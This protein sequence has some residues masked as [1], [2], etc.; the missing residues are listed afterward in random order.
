MSDRAELVE[1]LRKT[2]DALEADGATPKTAGE[3]IIDVEQTRALLDAAESTLLLQFDQTL[4]C[5]AEGF[6]TT[7]AW[8]TQRCQVASATASRRMKVARALPKLPIVAERFT[9]GALSFDQVECFARALNERTAD[10]MVEAEA[11]LVG[12][13]EGLRPDDFAREMR[14]WMEQ[15]DTDGCDPDP[16][17]TDRTMSLGQSIDSRW[18]GRLQLGSADGAV[19]KTALEAVMDELRKQEQKDLELDP[20]LERSVGQ[21]RVD[22]LMEIVRRGIAAN[23]DTA[24]LQRAALTLLITLEDFQADRGGQT[25]AGDRISPAGMDR[26]TCDSVVSPLAWTLDGV[27]LSHGRTRRL[28][29]AAQRRA[30]SARDRGCVFPGCDA[31]P[32]RCAGHHRKHWKRD[33]GPTDTDNIDLGAD[34]A[35]VGRGNEAGLRNKPEANENAARSQTRSREQQGVEEGAHLPT[36]H[37]PQDPRNRTSQVGEDP[38]NMLL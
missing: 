31:P 21:R 11:A 10:A 15:A 26:L 34:P 3:A 8:M 4:G 17:H 16:G 2:A 30:I 14:G 5:R 38:D 22:A 35:G 32:N 1:R 7:R 19:L 18:F 33:L 28:P 25:D 6:R 36:E 20:T 12:L 29:T 27:P 24:E 13:A 23:P 9:R 37:A